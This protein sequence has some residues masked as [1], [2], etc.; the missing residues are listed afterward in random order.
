MSAAAQLPVPPCEPRQR[1]G[2]VCQRLDDGA[3]RAFVAMT[4]SH[5]VFQIGL[6]RLE[7]PQLR[8]QLLDVGLGE[9]T[10]LAAG[11]LAVQLPTGGRS[12][13][14]LGSRPGADLD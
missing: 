3:F 13:P 10:D 6:D 12:R 8:I 7:F 1:R 14:L 9:R 2:I 4:A 11:T 5:Q